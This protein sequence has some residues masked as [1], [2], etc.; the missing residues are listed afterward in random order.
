MKFHCVVFSTRFEKEDSNLTEVEVDEV[1]GL[2]GNVGTE[3]SAHDAMPGWV[4][5]FVEFLLDECGDVLLDVEFL[6]SL[7]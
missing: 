6:E 1:L 4:V 5:L 3:V 2:V 7:G